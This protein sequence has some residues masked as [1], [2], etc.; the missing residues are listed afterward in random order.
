M[1]HEQAMWVHILLGSVGLL[2]FWGALLSRKGSERH[3][4]WGRPFFISLLAVA[5]SVGPL[6]FLQAGPF[7][8]AR[9][10]QFTYLSLCL[11][12]VTMLAWT[13]IRWREQPARFRG[14]HFKVLGPLLL[15]LG[16]VVLAAGLASGD[17]V[18]TVLSWVGLFHGALM[19]RFAWLRAPLLPNWWLN[20]HI[21]CVCSLFTAVHGT[22]AFTF[23]R[24]AMAPE[25]SRE[26]SAAMHLLVLGVAVGLRL[27]FGARRGVPLRFTQRVAST[28]VASA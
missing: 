20:W 13:A 26:V 27:W 28:Q 18:P 11:A 12:T 23:Y 10:V 3:K 25:A 15:A 1:T 22:F 7:N 6:L 2:T 24:W 16:A 19:V 21:T 9:V 14:L 8:P 17:P 5:L 4:R